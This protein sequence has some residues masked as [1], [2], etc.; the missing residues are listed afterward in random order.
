MKLLYKISKLILSS[1]IKFKNPEKTDLLIFDEVGK[2]IFDNIL[3]YKNYS[4]LEARYENIKNIYITWKI[5]YLMLKNLRKN[6]FT[7]YLISLMLRTLA[8]IIVSMCTSDT[9]N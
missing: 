5:I 8:S 3:Y 6:L 1:K 2:D 4:I 9:F 7:C